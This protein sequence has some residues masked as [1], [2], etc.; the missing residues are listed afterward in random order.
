MPSI[1][2]N[3]HISKCIQTV[4]PRDRSN[5]KHPPTTLDEPRGAYKILLDLISIKAVL[6]CVQLSLQIVDL[7]QLRIV[8][9]HIILRL[10]RVRLPHKQ[11]QHTVAISHHA[12]QSIHHAAHRFGAR[13]LA[14]TA[15]K[16]LQLRPT[17]FFRVERE[18]VLARGRHDLLLVH[19]HLRQARRTQRFRAERGLRVGRRVGVCDPGESP[20]VQIVSLHHIVWRSE[21]Q[22]TPTDRPRQDRLAHQRALLVGLEDLFELHAGVW[23]ARLCAELLLGVPLRADLRVALVHLLQLLLPPHVVA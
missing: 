13:Q 19:L 6:R 3:A 18:H 15:A 16:R 7:L 11:L 5:S 12:L 21:T 10:N 17:D 1:L 4:Y 22:Q 9:L 8:R 2:R 20:I 14:Q 23:I